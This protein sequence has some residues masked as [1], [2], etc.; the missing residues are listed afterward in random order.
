MRKDASITGTH[1]AITVRLPQRR[2][3]MVGLRP[4]ERVRAA[5]KAKGKAKAKA[6]VEIKLTEKEKGQTKEKAKERAKAAK[7]V[8]AKARVRLMAVATSVARRDWSMNGSLARATRIASGLVRTEEI[9]MTGP[10][11][12]LSGLFARVSQ[13]S[14]KP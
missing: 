7:A 3:L 8:K 10:G 9:R 6:V 4:Q 13:V 11:A 5:V 12:N 14:E 2:K 1:R